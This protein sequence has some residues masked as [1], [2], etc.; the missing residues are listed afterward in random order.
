MIIFFKSKLK[1]LIIT[2]LFV[3]I[4]LSYMIDP[5]GEFFHLKY[6]S[7]GIAC[8]IFIILGIFNIYKFRISNLQLIYIISFC[9]IMP[10]YGTIITFFNS[11]LS[12]FID[13]SYI[14]F[15]IFLLL[16]LPIALFQKNV[17]FQSLLISL[18]LL[19]GI[20]IL[21][22][23]SFI[24]DGDQ[25]GISQFFIEHKSMFVGFREYAGIT[26]YYLYF[27]AS[28]L[29]LILITY[30]AHRFINKKNLNNFLPFVITS[31]ALFLTGTRFN[32]LIAIIILPTLL[33]INQFKLK[34]VVTY[35]F[36]LLMTLVVLFQNSFTS[37]F[38]DTKEDSNSVKTGY[39][40]D[41]AIILS[42]PNTILFGQGFNAQDWSF[43]FKK[44][45]IKSYNEGTKTELSYFELFRVF[46]IFIGS[47]IIILL[48]LIPFFIYRKYKSIHYKF[49]AIVTYLISSALNPYLFSTNGVL[50]FIF[51]ISE[52]KNQD[53]GS[54]NFKLNNAYV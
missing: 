50:I 2:A 41:Y 54:S 29:L 36:L 8:L 28:P 32:M 11:N 51:I 33:F 10:I 46:G 15:S 9:I 52:F 43:I 23:I 21:V 12:T 7:T 45:L 13:S 3:F 35:T 37:S 49:L 39:F 19:T 44:M 16:L 22:L 38:F 40:E 31:S 27:T 48:W 18:R 42:S 20:I 4:I 26:T 34:Y 47:L 14:G 53:V 24:Y 5:T 30:D 1:N 6:I 25:I 17:F